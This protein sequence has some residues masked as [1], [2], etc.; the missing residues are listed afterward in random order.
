MD[1][2]IEQ[3]QNDFG[4]IYAIKEGTI[5]DKFIEQIKNDFGKWGKIYTVKDLISEIKKSLF[6]H[7]F[8]RKNSRL[9]FSVC[10]DD[11]NRIFERDT[12]ENALKKQFNGEFHLGGLAAY[13]I[14]GVAGLT[15]ASHHVPDNIVK[16]EREKGNLI[17][18]VS[19][20]TGLRNGESYIYGDVIRP[21]H[22]KPTSSCGAMIGFLNQLKQYK[23]PQEFDMP[24]DEVNIDPTR[25]VLHRELVNNHGDN[26]RKILEMRENNQQVIALTKLN[27][28]LVM[29]KT[30]LII[31]KFLEKESFKGNIVIIG[32]ITVNHLKG[33]DFILKEIVFQ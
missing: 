18:F 1:K 10:P 33:D 29:E 3:T 30:K 11:I 27:Y 5:I 7:D 25:V 9:V 26:L 8:N 28:D 24:E 19:P 14:G 6:E 23:N 4:E 32:G 2:F 22:V 13:P 15:A 21:G 31:K 20:H 17:L 16:G 12:V